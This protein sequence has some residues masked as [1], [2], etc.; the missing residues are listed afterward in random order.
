MFVFDVKQKQLF[1]SDG[2]ESKSDRAKQFSTGLRNLAV[3]L[4][5]RI[6]KMQFTNRTIRVSTGK[7][8][9]HE[10]LIKYLRDRKVDPV[11]VELLDEF[12]AANNSPI[13]KQ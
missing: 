4:G 1:G 3:R 2:V 13:T 11:E 7:A 12:F 10:G 5:G 8:S 6:T 9:V